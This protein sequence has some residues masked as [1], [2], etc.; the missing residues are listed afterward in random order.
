MTQYFHFFRNANSYHTNDR[1]DITFFIEI[2]Q[3]QK[4]GFTA[5]SKFGYSC[6]E[7]LMKVLG[8]S[9]HG[10]C[11]ISSSGTVPV[12]STFLRN[13]ANRECLLEITVG[14]EQTRSKDDINPCSN[15]SLEGTFLQQ[16]FKLLHMLFKV[17]GCRPPPIPQ[18]ENREIAMTHYSFQLLLQSFYSMP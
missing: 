18:S 7:L 8:S 11:P 5:R 1:Q 3:L 6:P 15:K 9:L 17:S 2:E 16:T 12:H 13:T 4:F 10:V 14:D